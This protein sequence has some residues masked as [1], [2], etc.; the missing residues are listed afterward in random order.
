MGEFN[1]RRGRDSN[2]PFSENAD[3]TV[4]SAE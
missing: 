1:W 4:L 3:I 2:H